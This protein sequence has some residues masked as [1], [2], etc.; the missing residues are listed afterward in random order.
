MVLLLSLGI[1][2]K[3]RRHEKKI[4]NGILRCNVY[5][6]QILPANCVVSAAYQLL[7]LFRYIGGNAITVVEGLDKLPNLQE[8][9]IENQKLAPGEKLLFDPR[10]ISALSV[11]VVLTLWHM[12]L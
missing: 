10:T 11:S 9:H 12:S 1:F 3:F 8:L 6:I 7:I 4:C 2:S 5:I